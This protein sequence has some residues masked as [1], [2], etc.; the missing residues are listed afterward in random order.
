MLK[1]AWSNIYCHPL[2]H[3]HRFPM[4]KYA[5]I[6]EQLRH[7]GLVTAANFFEPTPIA[8]EVALLTHTKA[9]WDHL[10]QGTLHPK[11]IR[12]I[13]FPLSPQLVLRE[14]IIAQGTVDAALYAL[15][16]GVAFNVAGGTHHAFA[17]SGDA[18][19]LLNDCAI[20]ANYL[21]HKGLAKNM[22]IID[23]D[24]HQGQGTAHIFENNTAVY[25]FSMHSQGSYPLKKERSNLDVPLPPQCS[26]TQYLELLS[27]A[28]ST[29][30]TN[31]FDFVF[32][33]AG[34]DVLATDKL[35]QLQLS[36]AH[37]GQRDRLVFD[38]CTQQG[39][40]IA[41]TMGGGYSPEI[42][43]IVTAHCNTYEVALGVMK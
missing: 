36:M 20:A 43:D 5:Q 40:P 30:A 12:R 23:L 28:L 21:L 16:H 6:P 42:S 33:V 24:V 8:E 26:G 34:V 19:C 37:C 22:L 35:G 3:G 7:R 38:F 29:L 2:P 31:S 4:Q 18:Y 25:T 17:D 9:Y 32:Y 14:R 39:L 1:I 11:I 15:Q 13:G 10:I 27:E 41:V